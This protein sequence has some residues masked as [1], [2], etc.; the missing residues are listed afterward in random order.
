MSSSSDCQP[1]AGSPRDCQPEAGSPP[2]KSDCQPEAGS[3]RDCQPEAGSPS[4]SSAGPPPPPP[5]SHLNNSPTLQPSNSP[6]ESHLWERNKA[7]QPSTEQQ[8]SLA[9]NPEGLEFVMPHSNSVRPAEPSPAQVEGITEDQPALPSP[10]PRESE[11]PW[12]YRRPPPLQ[13]VG[14]ATRPILPLQCIGNRAKDPPLSSPYPSSPKPSPRCP[15]G[16]IL[17]PTPTNL[18]P[19]LTPT[20]DAN[21]A[22]NHHTSAHQ[23]QNHP[24]HPTSNISVT[25][26]VVSPLLPN[27]PTQHLTNPFTTAFTIP[28]IHIPHALSQTYTPYLHS[29]TTAATNTFTPQHRST[30]P[31]ILHHYHLSPP[32]ITPTPSHGR[33]PDSP[34]DNL[35]YS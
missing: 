10:I 19:N 30:N 3:P 26:L 32:V 16:T 12:P 6:P 33:P 8:A 34:P 25:D 21:L 4:S 27:N 35:H 9:A 5:P 31:H 14:L 20:Q 24:P 22:Y 13:I 29:N 2:S 1:E 23:Y 28:S 18:D 7:N 15:V 11:D 17:S